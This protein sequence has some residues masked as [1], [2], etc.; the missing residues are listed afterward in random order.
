VANK[1]IQGHSTGAIRQYT[2]DLIV[3]IHCKY[4]SQSVPFPRHT[5]NSVQ[6][7]FILLR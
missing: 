1:V 7:S 3:V 6:Q 2:Y 4:M 5:H